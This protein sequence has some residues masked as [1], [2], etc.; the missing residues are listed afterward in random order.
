MTEIDSP[1]SFPEWFM[2]WPTFEVDWSRAGLLVVDFQN[3]GCNPECGVAE[4]LSEQFPE[5]ASYYLPQLREAIGNT[6]RL[7][8]AF[9]SSRREVVFT[10]HGALLSDGRDM[11][12][13]RR[14]RDADSVEQTETPTLWSKGSF[15]HEVVSDLA[16]LTDELVVDKNASSA[17]NGTGIDQLLRNLGLETLIVTGMATDMCVET[18]RK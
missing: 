14:Q 5:V 12:A 15:E 4:M 11:I 3:Y 6:Q 18:T 1:Q 16:P 13:R 8:E 10:R 7:L 9:R 2:P 17:F